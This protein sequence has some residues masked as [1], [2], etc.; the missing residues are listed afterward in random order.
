M[1]EQSGMPGVSD[2]APLSFRD[3]FTASPQFSRLFYEG[4]ALIEQ[5]ANYLDGPGRAEARELAPAESLAFSTES[6]QL[7]TR[8]MQLASWLLLRRAVANGQLSLAEARAHRRH[9]RLQPR[10]GVYAEAFASLPD[11][12]KDLIESSNSLHDRVLRLDRILGEGPAGHVEM[13]S[14]VGR[15]IERIRL[16]FHAA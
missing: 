13:Q 1:S 3:R 4:M 6:M 8:L 16:A 14:P 5:T 7:T 9:V 10:S 15:Q 12:L 2:A 11:R